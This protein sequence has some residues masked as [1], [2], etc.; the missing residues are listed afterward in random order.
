VAAPRQSVRELR[1]V[2]QQ[3]TTRC[4]LDHPNPHSASGYRNVDERPPRALTRPRIFAVTPGPPVQAAT[5]S[6]ISR[7]LLLALEAQGSLLGAVDGRPSLLTRVDQVA[8]FSPD[9]ERWRQWHNAGASSMS[10][11]VR[12]AMSEISGRRAAPHL[13][14]ANAV[15]QLTG[16]FAPRLP[17]HRRLL[18]CAYHDGNLAVFLRRPD[19]KIDPRSRRVRR[20]LEFERRLHQSRD[21]VMP[22]SEWL[23][24]SFIEDFGVDPQNVVAVGAGA[25]I[26]TT[27]ALPEQDLAKP[28][29]LFVG[30]QFDRKGGPTVLRA[31]AQLRRHRPD[32]ELWIVGPGRLNIVAPGVTSFGRLP[33]EAPGGIDLRKL[34]REATMFVMPSI[35]EPFGITFLEAMTHRL[36]CVGSTVGAIPEMVLDGVT[37]Y[38][39]APGDHAALAE[40]M[41]ELADNPDKAGQF[42]HAG[43]R[44]VRERYT[45]ER[46]AARVLGAISDRLK[47]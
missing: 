42:G 10:P 12:W 36:A 45:W 15:L 26:T 28:R 40:R 35:Y 11:L 43:L 44:H 9:R 27:E 2:V 37:G 19:L 41:I 17:P 25:N 38:V 6:G 30:K 20:A 46:V 7:S 1:R 14:E 22:M 8:S 5:F 16:W 23:R 13:A 29:I 24:R 3:A 21:L 32:A 18:K 4:T 33:H 31:F 34:Y 47:A 39:V